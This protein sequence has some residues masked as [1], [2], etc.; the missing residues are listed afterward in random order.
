M[1][2]N[3]TQLHRKNRQICVIISFTSTRYAC[4][5]VC[6]ENNVQNQI[7]EWISENSPFGLEKLVLKS[8]V[9]RR[10]IERARVSGELPH[11]RHLAERLLKAL[12]TKDTSKNQAS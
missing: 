11:S 4:N 3:S 2:Y 7:N 5:V 8:A 1:A 12:K 9:A 10:L 6:M